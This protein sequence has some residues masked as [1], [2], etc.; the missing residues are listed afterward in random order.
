MAPLLDIEYVYSSE[1]MYVYSNVTCTYTVM[2]EHEQS[3]AARA[4]EKL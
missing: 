1:Y 2:L 4:L 3:G